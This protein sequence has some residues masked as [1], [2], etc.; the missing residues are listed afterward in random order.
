M[1]GGCTYNK[2]YYMQQ[3]LFWNIFLQHVIHCVLKF[4]I[5]GNV[6]AFL[7]TW[8]NGV[9]KTD[10]SGKKNIVSLSFTCLGTEL[11]EKKKESI[12][13]LLGCVIFHKFSFWQHFHSL[14]RKKFMGS[15]LQFLLSYFSVLPHHHFCIALLFLYFSGESV[16]SKL[17]FYCNFNRSR[18]GFW[19][20]PFNS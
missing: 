5:V 12:E 3:L 16:F 13:E 15:T 17:V 11:K 1:L 18:W 10:S 14:R 7:P 2:S 20:T 9:N 19:N 8:N 4:L 6:W